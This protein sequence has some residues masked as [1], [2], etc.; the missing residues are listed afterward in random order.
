[1][2]AQQL[3]LDAAD[4]AV[5]QVDE[6]APDSWIDRALQ[7][8]RDVAIRH[9]FFTT[10]AVWDK[11]G[12]DIGEPRAMGAVMR[13]AQKQGVC[14]ATQRYQASH[15]TERHGGPMRVWRSLVVNDPAPRMCENECGRDLA[16]YREDARFCGSI[17]KAEFHRR[18]G[19]PRPP[20]G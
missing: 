1:M 16:G 14:E 18:G 5:V 17:C 10:D 4:E 15:R 20:V 11:L 9:Q 12:R 2:N 13:R 8:V 19:H 3:A 6:H 7:A